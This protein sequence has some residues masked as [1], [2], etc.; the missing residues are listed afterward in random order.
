MAEG[1]W[2]SDLMATTPLADAARL[3]LGV[4]LE[5]VRDYLQQALHQADKDPEYV[6]QLRVGTRRAVAAL[7]WSR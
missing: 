7:T 6:H 2:I 3:T 4:R 5:V 1:K